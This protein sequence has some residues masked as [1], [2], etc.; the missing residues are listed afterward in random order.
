MFFAAMSVV[1]NG[2]GLGS[3]VERTLNALERELNNA[4]QTQG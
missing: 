4:F 1:H 3:D 2:L